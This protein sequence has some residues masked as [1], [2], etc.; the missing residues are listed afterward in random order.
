MGLGGD[1]SYCSLLWLLIV[2]CPARDFQSR[3]REEVAVITV[4]Y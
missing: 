4:D 3:L 2:Y 1:D